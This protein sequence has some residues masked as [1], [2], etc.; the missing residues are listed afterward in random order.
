MKK[1]FTLKFQTILIVLVTLA[2][3]LAGYFYNQN[4][5]QRWYVKYS[6]EQ[7]NAAEGY[8][9]AIDNILTNISE[10]AT[11][12]LL[13]SFILKRINKQSAIN[14]D[15]FFKNLVISPDIIAFNVEGSVENLDKNLD[16]LILSINK[17]L[18]DEIVDFIRILS[19]INQNISDLSRKFKKDDLFFSLEFYEKE[20]VQ[21]LG[22]T[23]EASSLVEILLSSSEVTPS[24]FKLL[25]RLGTLLRDLRNTNSTKFL[26]LELEKLETLSSLEV[27][28]FEKV[29]RIVNKLS[30]E[31]II[32]INGQIEKVNL[33]PTLSVSLISFAIFG[34][35]LSIFLFVLIGI[36]SSK[37]G[38]KKLKALLNLK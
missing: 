13:G 19:E 23:E 33:S 36:F 3:T 35:S 34:F 9:S 27:L 38:I 30:N 21:P 2:F 7:T 18:Q 1:F 11:I 15:T 32:R 31:K 12:D 20:G 25:S 14:Q 4:L 24:T 17:N 29:E 22:L 5:K 16:M 37:I 26:E 8:V 10:F 28:N 6:I